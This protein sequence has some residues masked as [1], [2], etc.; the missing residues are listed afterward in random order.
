M[1]SLCPN[2]DFDPLVWLPCSQLVVM[3][4]CLQNCRQSHLPVSIEM[5][6]GLIHKCSHSH[7][8]VYIFCAMVCNV[9]HKPFLIILS[10]L[11]LSEIIYC[12]PP[13]CDPGQKWL[14]IPKKCPHAR[15]FLVTGFKAGTLLPRVRVGF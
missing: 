11:L 15:A 14:R 1:C 12:T 9:Q 2:V 3:L 7:L 8:L 4:L 13:L 10:L 5:G 6:S